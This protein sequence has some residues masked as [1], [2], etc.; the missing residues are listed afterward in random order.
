MQ[1][2][3]VCWLR[4]QLDIYRFNLQV[5]AGA[6]AHKFDA[7]VGFRPPDY[8]AFASYFAVYRQMQKKVSGI[9]MGDLHVSLAPDSEISRM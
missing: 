2:R 8:V 7:D 9:S 6:P 3:R 5:W 1:G 4:V